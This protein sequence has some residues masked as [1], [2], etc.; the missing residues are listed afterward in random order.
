[1]TTTALTE[2][3]PRVKRFADVTNPAS[4][5]PLPDDWVVGTT[6]V[7]S[8]MEAISSGR[9]KAVN[10]AGAAAISALINALGTTD[11]PFAFGG[12]GCA[13]AIPG[14]Y[15]DLATAVLARCRAWAADEL[16]LDLRA[17]LLPVA[18]I[19]KAGHDVRLAMYAPSAH[20]GY[21]LFDGGGVAWAEAEMKAGRIGVE[22]DRNK[23]PDLTGLSCR[24]LPIRPDDGAVLSLIVRTGPAGDAAFRAVIAEIISLTESAGSHPVPSD[25]PP[26][27]FISPGVDLEV[28]A[29]G[30]PGPRWRQRLAVRLHTL[31]GWALFRSRISLGGFHPA[32]YRRLA[33]DN[34]DVQKYGDGLMLTVNATP[35]V[36][37]QLHR[38]LDDS[39][40][41]GA[42]VFGLHSQ[43]AALMTCIVPSYTEDNHFHFI[44]GAGGGYAKASEALHS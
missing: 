16:E 26:P 15:H 7:V 39:A 24:W 38:L 19:R 20:V 44:D 3:F 43:S 35:A 6:D 30:K 2:L 27:A 9:Y 34:A 37:A 29:A 25:G 4:F 22:A 10:M 33:A 1:M 40:N 32:H 28:R 42:I 23:A 21:A 17:A 5:Q 13:F 8:S 11:I 12:D 14:E 31:L 36:E 41:S 18:D